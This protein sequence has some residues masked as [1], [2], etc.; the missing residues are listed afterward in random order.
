MG[1]SMGRSA[2]RGAGPAA[3]AGRTGRTLGR[4]FLGLLL[5]V[6]AA[7]A[8]GGEPPQQAHLALFRMI[9]VFLAPPGPQLGLG[10]TRQFVDGRHAARP[11]RRHA[12]AAGGMNAR[13]AGGCSGGGAICSGNSDGFG[14]IGRIVTSSIIGSTAAATAAWAAASID[15]WDC[16]GDGGGDAAGACACMR[17]SFRSGTNRGCCCS[18]RS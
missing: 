5:L 2:G 4:H 18:A 6:A 7:E 12:P 10:R 13:G 8:D 11:I 1:R 15:A 9:R 16:C 17:G 3:G 14:G